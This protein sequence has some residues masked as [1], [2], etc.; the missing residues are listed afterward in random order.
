[1]EVGGEGPGA[2]YSNCGVRFSVDVSIVLKILISVVVQ[3]LTFN[4]RLRR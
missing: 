1:M 2:F 4:F 3:G